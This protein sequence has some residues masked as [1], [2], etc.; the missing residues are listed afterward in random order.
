MQLARVEEFNCQGQVYCA[1]LPISFDVSK[2]PPPPCAHMYRAVLACSN[3]GSGHLC[4]SFCCPHC[5]EHLAGR[6]L[7]QKDKNSPQTQVS[8]S[9]ID[10]SDCLHSTCQLV[11]LLCTFP[12]YCSSFYSSLSLSFSLSLHLSL[13]LLPFFPF[14]PFFVLLPS[15]SFLLF[16]SPTSKNLT[17]ARCSCV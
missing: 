11:L 12:F 14:P 7:I 10:V 16:L 1:M 9:W 4:S 2:S 13:S 17:E 5:S 15:P 8:D 3:D 6:L